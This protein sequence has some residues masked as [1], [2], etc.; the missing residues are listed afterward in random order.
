LYT[1]LPIELCEFT[2]AGSFCVPTQ[3]RRYFELATQQP[4]VT[5]SSISRKYLPSSTNILL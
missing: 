4:N 5:S 2:I 1:I 3:R